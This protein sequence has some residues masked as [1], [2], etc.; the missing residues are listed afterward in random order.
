MQWVAL[1]VGLMVELMGETMVWRMAVCWD[2][3]SAARWAALMVVGSVEYLAAWMAVQ[4]ADLTGETM[5]FV[6]VAV[7][8]DLWASR[9]VA[10]TAAQMAAS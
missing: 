6:L 10:L 2:D 4:K 1:K 5:A 3:C 8:A 7:T 9:T